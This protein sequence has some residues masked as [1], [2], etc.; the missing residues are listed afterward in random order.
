MLRSKSPELSHEK[1]KSRQ[2]NLGQHSL[3]LNNL[4]PS[5][6]LSKIYI[7]STKN[8]VGSISNIR[9]SKQLKRKRSLNRLKSPIS[10]SPSISYLHTKDE[11][12]EKSF[13]PIP[14]CPENSNKI[15]EILKKIQKIDQMT[16]KSTEKLEFLTINED[17]FDLYNELFEEIIKKDKFFGRYLT[18]IKHFY[19]TYNKEKLQR[20]SLECKSKYKELE[21]KKNNAEQEIF[22]LQKIF[23][24][25]SRE[26]FQLSAEI[27]EYK[28]EFEK[29]QKKF[30]VIQNI[31][32]EQHFVGEEEWKNLIIENKYKG[33]LCARLEKQLEVYKHNQEMFIEKFEDLK[34]QGIQVVY[35]F[36]ESGESETSSEFVLDD[37]PHIKKSNQIPALNFSK[38][39]LR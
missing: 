13:S 32:N 11:N 28:K 27:E 19:D 25:L 23:E 34:K 26:N 20:Q 18:L 4:L 31:H 16:L 2:K 33:E 12:T 7:H 3:G 9:S 39:K 17:K 10:K 8:R 30:E 29:L 21:V 14:V 6:Q 15:E 24:S 22:S 35:E 5:A 37:P 38:L 1:T 36:S